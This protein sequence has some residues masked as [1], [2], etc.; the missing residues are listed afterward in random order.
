MNSKTVCVNNFEAPQGNG[1]WTIVGLVVPTVL[2]SYAADHWSGWLIF[3]AVVV[4]LFMAGVAVEM[5][6][7]PLSQATSAYFEYLSTMPV[8]AL[9]V[10]VNDQT[11]PVQTRDLI[12]QFLDE[13][14]S[15]WFEHIAVPDL[16]S[17]YGNTS[18]ED[19]A[20]MLENG[21]IKVVGKLV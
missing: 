14:H 13:H 20:A 15:G 4:G 10:A 21:S 6:H 5:S 1:F 12:R 7:R 19:I 8:A 18:P 11:K 9:A 17:I 2:V 16:K 3:A